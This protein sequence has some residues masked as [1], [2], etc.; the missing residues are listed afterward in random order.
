LS[1]YADRVA[2]LMVR[3]R[4]QRAEAGE[5]RRRLTEVTGTAASPRQSVRVT[6]NFRGEVLSLEFPTSAYKSMPPAELADT[7]TTTIREAKE[8]ALEAIRE[9]PLPSSALG[10]D[11][12]G[13]MEGKTDIAGL[14]EDIPMPDIV[15][16]YLATGRIP[17][18]SE[19]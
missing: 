16:D 11:I 8:K 5:L 18:A 9:L 12:A 6:V 10:L 2:E 15:R 17:S 1:G 7:I 4:E 3:Y 19:E 13:M 14:P